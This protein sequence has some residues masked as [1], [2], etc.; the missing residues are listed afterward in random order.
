MMTF[1][2]PLRACLTGLAL[3][4]TCAV[5]HAADPGRP[6][7]LIVPTP[8]GSAS[9]ALA[10]ALATPWGS[11]S[12]HPI[13]VENYAGAGTTIGMRQIARG[14]KDGLTLGV[15]S[16]NHTIN[17]WLYKNLPYDPIADFTPIAMIGTVPSMLVA[18]NR[19]AA[20]SAS[21]LVA[22]A[23]SSNTPLAEGVVSG[24]SYHLASE[25]FKE[26]AS[27]V[28]RPIPYKGTTQ[29]VT[30][31]LGGTIDIAFVAAQAAAPLVASGK[32]KG[33]AM[34]GTARS[35]VAPQVRTLKESGFPNFN[36]DVWLAIVGPGGLKPE[37]VA[38]RRKE[39]LEAL[40]SPDM[41]DTM[42]R[43]GVQPLSMEQ[44]AIQP[45]IK[46]ELMRNK[47]IVEKLQIS[48]D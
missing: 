42:R 15:M 35:E 38:A 43:Q 46:R 9:D 16:A 34:T 5:G 2:M 37:D 7:R 31:L 30:D 6:I 29:I 24:T 3:A 48:V 47:P 36:V 40:K 19:V 45:F 28:T 11:A 13:V 27:L 1:S 41:A 21:E 33:L 8:P 25:V 17:P 39:V 12:G 20:N 4:L 18:N 44:S 14:A 22:L 10:R 26:Q 32:L 23:R